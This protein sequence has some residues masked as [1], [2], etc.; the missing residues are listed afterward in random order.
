MFSFII[1]LI[2]T[3]SFW[4]LEAY[5]SAHPITNYNCTSMGK[6]IK[7][8]KAAAA[9]PPTATKATAEA[10][11]PVGGKPISKKQDFALMAIGLLAGAVY[12]WAGIG[13]IGRRVG[14]YN[15]VDAIDHVGAPFTQGLLVHD[16][17]MYE[18][19]GL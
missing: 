11:G 17:V 19:Y 15:V 1:H 10:A 2:S 3:T 16:G 13:A 6:R 14:P 7:Q 5:H 12:N 18:S 8:P 4:L 9:V